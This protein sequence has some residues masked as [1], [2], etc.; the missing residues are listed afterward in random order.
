MVKTF[1]NLIVISRI[2]VTYSFVISAYSLVQCS[3]RTHPVLATEI[4]N[5]NTCFLITLCTM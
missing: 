2:L 4:E 1:L 3:L 5:K